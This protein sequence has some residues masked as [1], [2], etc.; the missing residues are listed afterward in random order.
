MERCPEL[1]WATWNEFEHH[2]QSFL[3]RTK[4]KMD[5][6]QTVWICQWALF[7][8]KW[9][10]ITLYF[11]TTEEPLVTHQKGFW[12]IVGRKLWIKKWP[13]KYSHFLCIWQLTQLN[14]TYTIMTTSW[15]QSWCKFCYTSVSCV[16]RKLVCLTNRC[17]P[18]KRFYLTHL[19]KPRE[20]HF[21]N[22][23][24]FLPTKLYHAKPF[25][26]ASL[27]VSVLGCWQALEQDV[28]GRSGLRIWTR[29][30]EALMT[31]GLLLTW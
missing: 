10:P 16:A 26:T 4:T 21:P 1:P 12:G 2:T 24:S 19:G 15:F 3:E 5:N 28:V 31:W 22:T 14:L 13:R 9:I 29:E 8:E 25:R 23:T 30:R 27:A 20:R 18:N 11:N 17:C 7:F 6:V